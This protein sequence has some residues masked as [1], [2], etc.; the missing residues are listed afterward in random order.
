MVLTTRARVQRGALEIGLVHVRAVEMGAAEVG[1]LQRGAA[2]VGAGEMGAAEVGA[3][4]AG[5]DH[6]GAVEVRLAQ[7]GAAQVGFHQIG[8]VEPGAAQVGV[9]QA[10][11]PASSAPRDAPRTGWRASRRTPLRSAPRRS[12]RAQVEAERVPSSCAVTRRPSTAS[13]AWTSVGRRGCLRPL[14]IPGGALA[15]VGAEHLH[16]RLVLLARLVGDLLE[17]VDRAQAH[18]EAVV[19]ELADGAREA[20]APLRVLGQAHGVDGGPLAGGD[21]PPEQRQAAEHGAGAEQD[22]RASGAA[23]SAGR[24]ARAGVRKARHCAV[25]HCGSFQS[26]AERRAVAA[27][28]VSDDEPGASHERQANRRR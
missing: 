5:F 22:A 25:C 23:G 17:R 14:G 27:A 6:V 2:E 16:R 8:V 18:F 19:G 28:A 3:L 26:E 1:A 4:E 7:V 20:L 13:T 9:R 15:Q 11:A 12:V 10:C 21:P 24:A